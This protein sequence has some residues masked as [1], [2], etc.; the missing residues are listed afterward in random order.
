MNDRPKNTVAI[1]QARMGSSRLP[2]K[3]L[4][5]LAG[6]ELLI[7]IVERLK[8]V[9]SLD[10]IIVATTA[11]ETDNPIVEFCAQRGISVFAYG[12]AE[13]D[14]LGRYIECGE[15][16]SADAIVMVCGDCP[17][18][19]PVGVEQRVQLL[20]QKPTVEYAQYSGPTIE[21]GVAVL[22]LATFKKIA[23]LVKDA[24][25]HEH[26]TLFLM[27]H[28]DQF[29]IDSVEV[30][31]AF[32]DI[33]HR[34]WL[35][36]PADY[37]F[38]SELYKRLHRPGEVIDLHQVVDLLKTDEG[39]CALNAHVTQKQV[40]PYGYSVCLDLT[41]LEEG[42]DEKAIAVAHRLIEQYN[43][44]LRLLARGL[45]EQQIQLWNNQQIHHSDALPKSSEAI[46][47]I[48]GG[49]EGMVP[50]SPG[51]D[52]APRLSFGMADNAK[53]EK[54]IR[55][56][57]AYLGQQGGDSGHFVATL[58][59]SSD[60]SHLYSSDCPLCGGDQYQLLWRHSSGV[61]NAVCEACGHVFLAKRP[62]PE[63]IKASYADFKQSYDEA[64]LLD[65][66]NPLFALANSRYQ[67]LNSFAGSEVGAVLE[68]G[69][70]YGHFLSHFTESVFKVGIEPS[71]EQASFARR[72]FAIAEL[73][74]CGYEALQ[75][76]PESWPESGFDWICSYH[77]LEHVEQPRDFLGFIKRNLAS[78][79]ILCLAVP[80]LQTLSP[81]LIELFFITRGLHLHSFSVEVLENLLVSEGFEILDIKNEAET[82]MLRSSMIVVAKLAESGASVSKPVD[83][84]AIVDAGRR[85]HAE[86]DDR[87]DRLRLRLTEWQQQQKVVF[88]YG[89]GV[90]TKALLE[91]SGID[92]S[93]VVG[94]IDDDPEKQGDSIQGLDIVAYQTAI[95][96]RADVILVSSLASEIN[97]LTRLRQESLSHLELVGIYSDIF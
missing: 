52:G 89:G 83:Q 25:H 16:Y 97:I 61:T 1:I 22:R 78:G 55:L 90:H 69:C 82:P 38:L 40:R 20:L 44:G 19:D 21:G 94:I 34:L 41:G 96:L 51:E 24:A 4:L 23:G 76:S 10:H 80:N 9:P 15:Q 88:I 57:A 91:L 14:L 73:W 60:G 37:A 7:H 77:V 63:T 2:N 86:I 74:Q 62:A 53:I 54:N 64:Y 58:H 66:R 85:F 70:G 79:G 87:L 75:P 65:H 28:P 93:L 43:I 29:K 56:L 42:F 59:S 26:A 50:M 49:S 11:G 27:E 5:P 95:D 46:V 17:L 72:N 84:K 8:S 47:V 36:T 67:Y 48:H 35:D 12:G 13:D 92:N 45:N 81:D 6:S 18:F 31:K 33:K 71:A 68:V 3:V 32:R 30:D 39:L